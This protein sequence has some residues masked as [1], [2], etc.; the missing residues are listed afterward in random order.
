M[1][2]WRLAQPLAKNGFKESCCGSLRAN[3]AGLVP[4]RGRRP[5]DWYPHPIRKL[6]SGQRV[7]VRPR[8]KRPQEARRQKIAS[9]RSSSLFHVERSK[10]VDSSRA[11]TIFRQFPSARARSSTPIA[12]LTSCW[13]SC[14]RCSSVISRYRASGSPFPSVSATRSPYR[15]GANFDA[16]HLRVSTR[17][18]SRFTSPLPSAISSFA[19]A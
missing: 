10:A 19:R 3:E 4:A 7:S 11:K 8:W 9:R 16:I 12:S 17:S 13:A 6:I 14:T 2:L 5:A 1:P 18:V 15:R